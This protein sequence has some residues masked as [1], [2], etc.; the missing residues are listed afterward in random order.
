MADNNIAK[1]NY[2]FLLATDVFR[3]LHKRCRNSSPA[4][5]VLPSLGIPLPAAK[6]D[7]GRHCLGLLQWGGGGVQLRHE[8]FGLALYGLHSR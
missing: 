4:P 5:G 3:S 8:L 1:S 7:E 6:V 2:S